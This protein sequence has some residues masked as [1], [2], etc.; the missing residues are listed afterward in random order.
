MEDYVYR[1]VLRINMIPNVTY[2]FMKGRNYR[3]VTSSNTPNDFYYFYDKFQSNTEY[4]VNLLE[5]A[6]SGSIGLHE[7]EKVLK[8]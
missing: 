6:R 2:I 7:G 1:K 3:E 5:V 4:K 8:I